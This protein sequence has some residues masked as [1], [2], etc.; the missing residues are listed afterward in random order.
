MLVYPPVDR[1]YEVRMKTSNITKHAFFV[2]FFKKKTYTA[3]HK[4]TVKMRS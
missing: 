3:Q 1:K 2:S 4:N